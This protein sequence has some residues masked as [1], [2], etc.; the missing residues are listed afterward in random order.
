M[1][2]LLWT[3]AHTADARESPP[4]RAPG[5]RRSCDGI[6]CS[7]ATRIPASITNPSLSSPDRVECRRATLAS[8]PLWLGTYAEQPN[9]WTPRDGVTLKFSKAIDLFI[10]DRKSQG[11]INSANTESAYREKLNAHCDDVG[12]A[13]PA[14]TT[15]ADLKRTL[16]RWEHPNSQ[17]QAHA[18]LTTFYDWTMEEEI[19][20]TNPARMVL[21]AKARPVTVYRP[22]R[23]EVIALM[24]AADALGRR[25]RWV[26]HLG[27]LAGL[28]RQ[29]LCGLQGRHVARKGVIWVS[30]DIGKGGRERV[31]PVLRELEPIVAEITLMIAPGKYVIPS[32]RSLN[33]PEHTH[34]ADREKPMSGGGMHKL[35]QRVGRKAGLGADI[36]PHTLRHGFGDHIARYAGLRAAQEML[37]H[38][39]VATTESSYTGRVSVEELLVSVQGFEFRRRDTPESRA[40][41]QTL[42]NV[43]PGN[44]GSLSQNEEEDAP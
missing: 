6:S 16:R 35:V 14:K 12:D 24:D 27:L 30:G 34:Q 28:R 25:E 23:E 39:N 9:G 5:G 40:V 38:A 44:S 22:T 43:E 31:I 11:R 4:R 18:I 17:R 15:R 41:D 32:R 42:H 3:V 29:E 1:R 2:D 33:P 20:D 7:G 21:R 36:G 37:G 13:D 8:P 19:R 26:I 10:T